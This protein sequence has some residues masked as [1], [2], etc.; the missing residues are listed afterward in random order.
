MYYITDSLD[1]DISMLFL[2]TAHRHYQLKL[3]INLFFF[4]KYYLYFLA[5]DTHIHVNDEI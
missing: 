3:T 1:M 2:S 4:I 5:L